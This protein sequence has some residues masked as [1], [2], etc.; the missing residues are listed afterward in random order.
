MDLY[1]SL[2]FSNELGAFICAMTKMWWELHPKLTTD[3]HDNDKIKD[4]DEGGE[5]STRNFVGG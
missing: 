1:L 4:Q 2:M 5:V 3:L